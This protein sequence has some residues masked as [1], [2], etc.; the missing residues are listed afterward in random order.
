MSFIE[1]ARQS[2]EMLTIGGWWLFSSAM[3]QMPSLSSNAGF[4]TRWAHDFFQFIAANPAKFST[5]NPTQT[6][7]Q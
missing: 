1:W 7:E 3:S 5:R 4:F 6:K 2:R